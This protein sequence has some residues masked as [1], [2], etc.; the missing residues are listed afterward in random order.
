[1]TYPS[2]AI[3]WTCNH[4]IDVK[5][6]TL[7]K[8]TLKDSLYCRFHRPAARRHAK[9]LVSFLQAKL[10]ENLNSAQKTDWLKLSNLYIQKNYK[11]KNLTAIVQAFDRSIMRHRPSL[12]LIHPKNQV[13]FQKWQRNGMP[14]DFFAKHTAF[15]EF[16]ETSNLLS[17]IKITRDSLSEIDGEPALK[18]DGTLTKWSEFQQNFDVVYSK[19]YKEN[20]VVRKLTRDVYTYLDN[21][22]GLQKHHPYL[23]EHPV[24][25]K[26]DESEYELVLTE[27]HKFERPTEKDLSQDHKK[28]LNAPRTFILQIVSSY[29]EG[30]NTNFNELLTKPQHPYLHLIAGADDPV[31]NIS[32][33][34][35]VGLGF[36]LENK[37]PFPLMAQKG[38]FRSPDRWEYKVCKER[39]VTNIALTPEEAHELCSYTLKYHRDKVNLGIETGFH[40]LRQNCTTYIKAAA[41]V[42]GIAVP[43]EISLVN[44]IKEIAPDW[45]KTIGRA[46]TAAKNG[47]KKG[48]QF[49]AK[50]ILPSCVKHGI[51]FI[52]NKI[53]AFVQCFFSAIGALFLVPINAILG[54][55]RSGEGGVA[56][57]PPKKEAKQITPP[58]RKWK[59]WFDL[60]SYRFTLP[61][62][63]QK[64]QRQQASTV[65]YKNPI[66]LSIV[67]L[68][69][70]GHLRCPHTG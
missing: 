52:S 4:R 42:A 47:C 26:I 57:V 39:V 20:L 46:Y 49:T 55:G 18:V 70:P 56:F 54:G 32:K 58:L 51:E 69:G 45:I 43:T 41:K 6:D 13:S 34:D 11:N 1:M 17:Q 12:Q 48:L 22:L 63:L 66:K 50:K 8:R 19:R 40:M 14:S 60:S 33:G 38:R 61:G 35:V 67:P 53:H 15:C 24:I 16:L 2:Q 3:K 44:L 21:G 29:L 31:L 23:S 9:Q 7:V 28:K 10:Q 25:S 30:T 62:I 68:H 65:I 64:W 36:E 5:N 59:T 37:V 27:A